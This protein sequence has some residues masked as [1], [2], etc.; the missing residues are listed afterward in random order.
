M[1]NGEGGQTRRVSV[2]LEEEDW[3]RLKERA[4]A[5]GTSVSAL[6]REATRKPLGGQG[7]IA[8]EAFAET[9]ANLS[10]RFGFQEVVFLQ[11]AQDALQEVLQNDSSQSV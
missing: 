11:I 7:Y 1:K 10:K 4:H 9:M 6:I 3:R 5:E 2:R 8:K